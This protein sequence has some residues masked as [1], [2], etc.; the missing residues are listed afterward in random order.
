MIIFPVLVKSQ[1]NDLFVEI[2]GGSGWL[3]PNY[4][5]QN[6]AGPVSLFNA[7]F[8]VKTI[9]KKEWQ[10]VFNYPVIGLGIANNYLS[11]RS[12]GNPKAVYAFLYLPVL[13]KSILHLNVGMHMGFTWGFN[14]YRDQYPTEIV[15]GSRLA[16]YTSFNLNNSIAISKHLE[17][18]FS[19]EAYHSSNGNTNKPNK[20]INI[21]GGE[22]GL[23]YLFGDKPTEKIVK[24]NAPVKKRSS[25]LLV[26]SFG[27]LRESAQI[28]VMSPVGS[29]SAGYYKVLS[30]KSTV[31]T[32]IDLF[33]NEGI[34]LFTNQSN[35][36]K[37]V[38]SAGIFAGHELTVG[39]LA[40]VTQAGIY[41]RN[42]YAKDPF[43][44]ER[45]G[46]R[47]TVSQRLK[48]SLCIKV[49]GVEV[50]FL[51]VGIGYILWKNK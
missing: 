31:S 46:V 45:I 3:Y 21:M 19:V 22:T 38:M 32:G 33:Y 11:T 47:Y 35:Q 42:P 7:K 34:L 49:H 40:I 17:L 12:L 14:P 51:E 20:G 36:L 10:R 41:L 26:G 29:L 13:P 2:N 18:V 50:N 44:Y 16:F 39:D 23:R 43:H 4:K 28:N 1:K 5:M 15:I 9:G 6:L 37:N 30:H 27:R 48:P 8:G 25:I 24:E